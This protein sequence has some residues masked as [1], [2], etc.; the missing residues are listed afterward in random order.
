VSVNSGRGHYA[1]IHGKDCYDLVLEGLRRLA[2][3]K[4]VKRGV[5]CVWSGVSDLKDVQSMLRDVAGF[6]LD[7][8]RIAPE[9]FLHPGRP[10]SAI[11]ASEL[12]AS[13]GGLRLLIESPRMVEV[14]Q[15]CFTQWYKPVVDANGKVYACTLRLD[16]LCT[17]ESMEEYWTRG[18]GVDVARCEWC[19][20]SDVNH[21]LMAAERIIRASDADF[22]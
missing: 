5:S 4:G 22:M 15:K 19:H 12:Q 8:I 3:F 18:A 16:H 1:A 7:H 14:P 6:D 9:L 17:I 13:V 10:T 11:P 21:A 20:F 2:T